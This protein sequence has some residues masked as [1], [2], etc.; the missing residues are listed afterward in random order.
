MIS[1]SEKEELNTLRNHIQNAQNGDLA[2]QYLVEYIELIKTINE[3]DR[4]VLKGL[5]RLEGFASDTTREV[6]RLVSSGKTEADKSLIEL[7]GGSS[8][9]AQNASLKKMSSMIAGQLSLLFSPVEV[10]SQTAT[11][12]FDAKK[13]YIYFADDNERGLSFATR[14]GKPPKRMAI[15]IALKSEKSMITTRL[16]ERIGIN[17]DI[18]RREIIEINNRFAT[19]FSGKEL[20]CVRGKKERQNIYELNKHFK[21]R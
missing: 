19:L 14:N 7:V 5:R 18:L 3:A 12:I 11:L 8:G 13:S 21:Y 9:F 15:L 6:Y 10:E 1:W 17:P 2:L 4:L 16:A 20:V